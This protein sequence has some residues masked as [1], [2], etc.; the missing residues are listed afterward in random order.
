MRL[1]DDPF[2]ADKPD[3]CAGCKA[4]DEMLAKFAAKVDALERQLNLRNVVKLDEYARS[5]LQKTTVRRGK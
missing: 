1:S 3:L 2:L 5:Q 4:R